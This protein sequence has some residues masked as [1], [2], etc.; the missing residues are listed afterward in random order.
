[1]PDRVAEPL[2]Q[3][4][5]VGVLGEHERGEPLDPLLVGPLDQAL[6][7]LPAEATVLPVVGDDDR[8]LGDVLAHAHEPGDADRVAPV[9]SSATSASWS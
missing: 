4:Q 3:P 2:E 7:Q 1:M 5:R 8:A 9:R 6:E